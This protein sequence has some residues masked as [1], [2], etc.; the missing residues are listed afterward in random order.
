M[1]TFKFERT[2]DCIW[3]QWCLMYLTDEDLLKYLEECRDH[4]VLP[5]VE[6]KQKEEE[7][8]ETK[9]KDKAPLKKP[10]FQPQGLIF[11]KENVQPEK[12]LVDREDNSIMRTD[13]HFKYLFENAGLEI[14]HD[15]EQT[16]KGFEEL[17]E[18]HIYV[19]CRN[20][21]HEKK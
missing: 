10:A 5:K 7:E 2:Y 15:E 21:S 18:V 6:E 17:F 8:E 1:Q 14:L 4:L 16:G 3:T 12:F 9:I 19:L 13:E 11:V 20:H